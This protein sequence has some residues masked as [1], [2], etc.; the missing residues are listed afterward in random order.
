M[1]NIMK[2]DVFEGFSVFFAILGI[3]FENNKKFCHILTRIWDLW[4]FFRQFQVSVKDS[5]P[6]DVLKMLHCKTERKKS[7]KKHTH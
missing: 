2:N 7:Q 3:L 6:I 1:E 4:Q 5:S